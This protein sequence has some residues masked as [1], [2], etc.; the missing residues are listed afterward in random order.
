MFTYLYL[1]TN[2]KSLQNRV[3]ANALENEKDLNA[4]TS[5]F[6]NLVYMHMHIY[7]CHSRAITWRN[8]LDPDQ[9]W[10]NISDLTLTYWVML[11]TIP[12]YNDLQYDLNLAIIKHNTFCGHLTS[13]NYNSTRNSCKLTILL[14]L[15]LLF[16]SV[17]ILLNMPHSKCYIYNLI[18]YLINQEDNFCPSG[19]HAQCVA[20]DIGHY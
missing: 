19:V 18:S 8:M 9:T 10:L 12:G 16:P 6:Y 20:K 14:S 3:H 15:W 13:V 5:M 4:F 17:T 11:L 7:I 2:Y 1:F